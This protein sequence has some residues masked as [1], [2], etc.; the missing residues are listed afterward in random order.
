MENK[1]NNY[2][3]WN[4][5]YQESVPPFKG[6]QNDAQQTE[7]AKNE[8]DDGYYERNG[9]KYR[10]IEKINVSTEEG[11][12][13][14]LDSLI[15]NAF[16][17][18]EQELKQ[19]KEDFYK[20]WGTEYDPKNED[21]VRDD[22]LYGSPVVSAQRELDSVKRQRQLLNNVLNNDTKGDLLSTLY[23]KYAEYYKLSF[24]EGVSEKF[25]RQA[26]EDHFQISNLHFILYKR[27]AEADPSRFRADNIADELEVN[28]RKAERRIKDT[29]LDGIVNKDGFIYATDP[30]GE[31][32][33]SN[34]TPEAEMDLQEAKDEAEVFDTIQNYEFSLPGFTEAHATSPNPEKIKSSADLFA[35]HHEHGGPRKRED[36]TKSIDSFIEKNTQEINSLNEQARS[37]D[38]NSSDYADIRIRCRKLAKE[39]SAARRL[40]SKYFNVLKIEKG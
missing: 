27:I 4:K 32:F 24:K 11:R 33:P 17:A 15:D 34:L 22:D 16:M 3:L 25:Q 31:K 37:M 36:F 12:V 21:H 35:W 40:K 26:E 29:K 2:R 18:R 38:K 30:N 10:N 23:T 7:K 5:S 8:K 19:A 9:I 28:V 20:S 14:Y 39:R 13:E 6:E 1:F